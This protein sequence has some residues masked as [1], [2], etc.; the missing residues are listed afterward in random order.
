MTG[1][2]VDMCGFPRWSIEGQGKGHKQV[3]ELRPKMLNGSVAWI[4]K[5]SMEALLEM[6]M[7][8]VN[9]LP[10]SLMNE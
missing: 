2:G 5:P 3:K 1:P 10:K 7:E 6:E 8:T 9:Q 4:M